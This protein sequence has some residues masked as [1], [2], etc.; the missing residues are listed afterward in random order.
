MMLSMTAEAQA[1]KGTLRIGDSDVVTEFAKLSDNTVAVGNGRNACMS[2]YTG[3]G[4][5]TI[6]GEVNIDGTD[7]KVTRVSRFAFR[8]CNS[9][10]GVNIQENIES[11][12]EF[13]FIGCSSI[14]DI[15]LPASLKSIGAGAFASSYKTLETVTCLGDEPATWEDN[16][17]FRHITGDDLM[18]SYDKQLFVANKEKYAQ[19]NGWKFFPNVKFGQGTYYVYDATDLTLLRDRTALGNAMA[20]I[21]DVVLAQDIDMTGV[22]WSHGMGLSEEEPFIAHFDG[23][24]HT[25][26]NL[27]VKGTDCPAFISHYGGALIENVN[28]RNCKSIN[29][30]TTGYSAIV[31]GESGRFMLSKVWV[32]NSIVGG[33]QYMGG[34]IGHCITPGL[35]INDCVVK[36]ID[37]K[38]YPQLGAKAGALV[39][40]AA[41]GN[42]WRCAVIGNYNVVVDFTEFPDVYTSPFRDF[43][44]V[45]R[46]FVAQCSDGDQFQMHSSYASTENFNNYTPADFMAYDSDAVIAG[47]KTVDIIGTDGTTTQRTLGENDM[48]TLLMAGVLGRQWTY[49]E[50]QYPLPDCYGSRFSVEVNKATYCFN[51]TSADDIPVNCLFAR[52]AQPTDFLNLSSNGYIS[53]EYETSRIWMDDNFATGPSTLPIGT[54]T[55]V[56]TGGVIYDRTLQAGV[57]YTAVEKAQLVDADE[58]GDL[59]LTTHGECIPVGDL[60]VISEKE[61]YQAKGNSMC[62]PFDIRLG[63]TTRVFQPTSFGSKG[64]LV[65]VSMKEAE[66]V[67][68]WKP[69]IVTVEQEAVP[70]S[71]E[72]PVTFCPRPADSDFTPADSH[73]AMIGSGQREGADSH[74]YFALGDDER[75]SKVASSDVLPFRAYFTTTEGKGDEQ[76][77]TGMGYRAEMVGDT[78]TFCWGLPTDG[79][80]KWWPLPEKPGVL[81]TWTDDVREIHTARF[82]DSFAPARPASL[83]GWFRSCEFL[84]EIIDIENLNT[85]ETIDM[86]YLFS[87]C[88][89][90]E[91]LDISS[92]VTAKVK[93]TSNMFAGCHALTTVIIGKDWDMQPVTKSDKMFLDCFSIIG[94]TG[95]TYLAGYD[96]KNYA[97]NYLWGYL[98]KRYPY[99]CATLNSNNVMMFYG[100]DT[101]PDGISTFDVIQTGSAGPGWAHLYSSDVNRAHFQPSFALARPTS[102]RRWFASEYLTTV[103]GLE[104]LNTSL[105]TD[106]SSMFEGCRVTSLDLAHFDTHNVT[107]MS[108]M[109]KDCSKLTTLDVT[110]FNTSLVT[111]MQEMFAG[112][113]KLTA[114]DV[115][116]LKTF[117]V[118]TMQGMFSECK[119]L[120]ELDLNNFNIGKLDNIATMFIHCG[121]LRTI[122]CD[123]SWGDIAHSANMFGKCEHLEGAVKYQETETTLDG[124]M[125]NPETGY[126]MA[127]PAVKLLDMGDNSEVFAK[128][129]GKRANVTYDRVLRAIDNG[130]GTYSSRAYTICLPYDLNIVK[131]WV[132]GKAN[133]YMLYAITDN[134]EFV[135]S[136]SMDGGVLKAGHAYL[137]VVN[138]GEVSLNANRVVLTDQPHEGMDVALWDNSG[139]R[140]VAGKWRGTFT[141]IESADAAAMFAYSLQKDGYFKRIRP[142]T[143]QA[144]W[145]AFRAMFCANEFTGNNVYKPLFKET[146]AGDDDPAT[147]LPAD[148]FEG[149][150]DIP[151]ETDGILHIINRDGTHR[152]FDLQGRQLSGKPTR[153]G[154]YI[155]NGKKVIR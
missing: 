6:P 36:D 45:A 108:A 68:A 99:Y 37:M 155:Y 17:V 74:I 7:Y 140:D 56:S 114:L 102:C 27:T 115:T 118:E 128:Y 23:Q 71:I 135:F 146:V 101:A 121:E 78:L 110:H 29:P 66:K 39:G 136:N 51:V 153:K 124:R 12:E 75:W 19:A 58:N 25:I 117:N 137:V 14:K 90:L 52:T 53:K 116:G 64:E 28:F 94:E 88:T 138:E 41:S 133:V 142:D 5:L 50:N 95:R 20:Y 22:T 85:S 60:V 93:N 89:S 30:S 49:A 120:T 132:E 149:D 154:V 43:L 26:S 104:R 35:N 83:Y 145:G 81:P 42:A 119:A 98:W 57:T 129:D 2:Q 34:L 11:I 16:D 18:Y 65:T 126:F 24:G 141:K 48:R 143:P 147:D 86:Q 112:C 61:C 4:L 131:N 59:A 31:V 10:T 72:A 63:G 44:D 96:D 67:E 80:L 113:S 73:Y 70:L 82:E 69:C 134:K 111:T 55:I 100:S 40:L 76:I 46:P 91:Q 144:W 103:T 97:N 33:G 15:T 139:E 123:N 122:W 77:S 151:D 92:F 106:M 105:V 148:T 1:L 130:D 125:A 62:L 109:F 127:S 150:T 152:Y 79:E 107:D 8:F 32:E 87:D 38:P 9:I 21:K 13:A 54:A 3:S 84:D 47:L